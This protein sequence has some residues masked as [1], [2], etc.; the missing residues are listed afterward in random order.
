MIMTR[1]Q[2]RA[3]SVAARELPVKPARF[4][5]PCSSLDVSTAGSAVC[6]SMSFI[7]RVLICANLWTF[8]K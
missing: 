2:L 8:L 5:P 1:E 4:A 7:Q 3:G 6:C